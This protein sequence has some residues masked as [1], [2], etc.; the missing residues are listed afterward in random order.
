M[1]KDHFEVFNKNG[2]ISLVLNLD[3]SVNLSKTEVAIRQGRKL[4]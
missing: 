2:K 4:K 1:H 3:G